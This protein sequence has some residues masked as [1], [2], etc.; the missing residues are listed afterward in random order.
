MVFLCLSLEEAQVAIAGGGVLLATIGVVFAGLAWRSAQRNL[1]IAQTEH[2]EF[3]RQI[4]ARADFDLKVE[5]ANL[6]TAEDGGLD[7]P[8]NTD[9]LVR[10]RLGVTNSGNKA[11][12]RTGFNFL[13]PARFRTAEWTDNQGR[14]STEASSVAEVADPTDTLPRLPHGEE[15]HY[16]QRT[17]PEIRRK[18]HFITYVNLYLPANAFPEGAFSVRFKAWADELP[19]GVEERI[20]ELTVPVRQG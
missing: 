7:L 9:H 6:E 14:K 10:F 8:P 19:D 11:A 3:M 1:A 4:N 12:E 15:I 5:I 17:V 16:L 2:K 20:E 13:F 18:G